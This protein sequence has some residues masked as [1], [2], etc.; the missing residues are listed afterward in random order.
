MIPRIVSRFPTLIASGLY[1][2][3]SVLAFIPLWTGKVLLPEGSD[4]RGGYPFRAFAAQYLERY[5]DVPGWYPYIFGGMPYAANTAHGDTFFPTALLRLLFDV[6]VGMAIGFFIFTTLAGIFAFVF[7]RGIGLTW[8][9]SFIGGAAYMFTG[10][11]V[12]MAS[13]GH[14]GKLFV[15]ALLPL[16]LFFL[17]RA[18]AR[19]DWRQYVYFGVTVGFALL[20]PHF[21]MTYYLL[22]AAGFFWA[23]MVFFSDQK[24]GAEPWWR[25]AL[26][27]GGSLAI[28]FG[29]AAIQLVPFMNYLPFSPRG[30]AGGT[31]TG[32]A[33]ATGWSMPPE[34]LLNTVWPAF[35]GMLFEY[36]GRNQFK[37][38]SEYVGAAVALLALLSF[39]LRS[40]RR[41]AWFFVFLAIYATLFA[42]GGYTPLYRIP[43]AI[44]PMIKSTRAV[45]MIFTL[46]SFSVAVLAAFGAEWLL[47]RAPVL[48]GV[49]KRVETLSEKGLFGLPKPLVIGVGVFAGV[50]LLAAAGAFRPV[51]TVLG[52]P[53]QGS[54]CYG[55]AALCIESAYPTFIAGAFRVLLVGIAVAAMSLPSSRRRW[56]P[57]TWALIM[58][59]IVLV[60]LYSVERRYLRFSDRAATELAAD[61]VVRVLASDTS[62]FRVLPQPGH[63]AY[64]DNYLM[65]HGIRSALGYNGQELHRYDELLGGKNRWAAWSNQNLWR[66][67]GVKYVILEQPVDAPML[68]PVGDSLRTHTGHPVFVYRLTDP[69]PYAFLVGQ[70]LRLRQPGETSEQQIVATVLDQG[71]DPRRLLLLPADAP[72]GRDTLSADQ[73][74]PPI[75]LPVAI[76]EERPG[77]LRMDLASPAPDSAYLFVAENWYPKW[78]ATVDGRPA[79]VLRAQGSLMAVPVPPGGRSVT[80][81]FV[82]D[83]VALG[84]R[85]TI[86]TALAVII[87]AIVSAILTRRRRP[88][89]PA[90]PIPAPAAPATSGQAKRQATGSH[91]H[92]VLP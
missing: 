43:Y 48:K 26:L 90:V 65:V 13:P 36:W 24:A 75:D 33:Y 20:T 18:T 63:R 5:G 59:L 84:R 83:D 42:F 76:R 87:L 55:R 7:L 79:P 81:E 50:A 39:R 86:L 41:M 78:K 25:S 11:V 44:L 92:S 38:H 2:L 82:A 29:I 6:D 70:A 51:M 45:S 17:Y 62:L 8:G 89:T 80:L 58:G 60:D 88:T 71:F 85:I 27:F 34:E 19:R 64:S 66:L 57:E 91:S 21:Q 3:V 73:V 40:H 67:L 10:Q 72:V 12:S 16:T 23:F 77:L 68:V 35:S 74:A 46:A 37:L 30:A 54:D 1:I 22:M 32:Y 15:S 61:D 69:G 56:A 31:S 47:A 28:G 14:D 9:P 53:P 49:G 4:Q 52:D